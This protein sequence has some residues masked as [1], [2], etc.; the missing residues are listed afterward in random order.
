MHKRPQRD[1]EAQ[2]ERFR[3]DCRDAGM[4]LTHQREVI[5]RVLMEMD[6][7]PSPE[8]IYG[9]VKK[10]IPAISLATVYKNLKTFLDTGL[11]REVSLH[12]GALRLETNSLPHHH[13]VCTRCK[14][15]FDI[16]DDRLSPV[17]LRR[18]LPGGFR[19]QRY[20]VEFQGLCGRCAAL[21][22]QS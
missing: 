5:F 13:F 1:V 2:V 17:E 9:R 20:S 10:Q 4:S 22:S 19:L 14:E 15:I 11:A 21:E 12:H 6:G 3:Q 8:A 7:H 16:E 18:E